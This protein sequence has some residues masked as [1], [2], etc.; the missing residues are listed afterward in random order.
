[1]L[2]DSREDAVKAVEFIIE[3]GE[4]APQNRSGSHYRRFLDLRSA[5][6][7]A[8]FDP[9]RPVAA[10]PRTRD[11]RDARSRGTMIE[12]DRTRAVAELFN[13]VYATVL[14]S[15]PQIEEYLEC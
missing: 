9:A 4:R 2:V 5:L 15:E 7:T 8:R 1:L 11:H 10:N 6:T 3:Q 13:H 12:N 14:L